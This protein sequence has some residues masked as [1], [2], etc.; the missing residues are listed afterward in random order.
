MSARDKHLN[1]GAYC[2][3]AR[4][5]GNTTAKTEQNGAWVSRHADNG[6]LALSAKLVVNYSAALAADETVSL[7]AQFQD[8]VES[9][10]S[11]VAD[12]GDAVA[13]TVLATGDSGGSTEV[14]TAEI[15]IDLS[16]ARAFLRSQITLATS[17]SGTVAYSACLVFFGDSRTPVTKST[18]N[19]NSADSI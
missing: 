6:D 4:Q 16:A 7:A 2:R 13:A 8:A 3:T 19:V 17:A 14:G 5:L 9:D 15:D 18:V 1:G 11:G 10:G 12:F